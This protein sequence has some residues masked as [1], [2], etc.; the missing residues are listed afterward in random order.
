MQLLHIKQCSG[1]PRV[2]AV[3]VP[4]SVAVSQ[5]CQ[6]EPPPLRLPGNGAALP[7]SAL[8][9][10]DPQLW[11]LAGKTQPQDGQLCIFSGISPWWGRIKMTLFNLREW[12]CCLFL[13]LVKYYLVLMWLVRESCF[14][15]SIRLEMMFSNEGCFD[16]SP[17]CSMHNFT[18]LTFWSKL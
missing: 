17:V 9:S 2:C 12:I 16:L 5:L 15:W 6:A 18:S 8:P 7:A 4:H 11:S 10:G 14:W 3:E 1:C 13:S